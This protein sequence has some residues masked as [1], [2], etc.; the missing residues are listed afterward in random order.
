MPRP[1]LQPARS[2]T[3]SAPRW[4]DAASSGR[5][6]ASQGSGARGGSSSSA[7]TLA[8][9]GI[10]GVMSYSVSQR[11]PEIGIR[12]AL[13]ARRGD[14]LLLVLGQT[15]T[16]TAGGIAI[17]LAASLA[18]AHLMASL[19]YGV[20]PVDPLT[21]AAVAGLLVLVAA[22][23]AIIPARRAARVDPMVALRSE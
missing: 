18:L 2:S 17:G 21:F 11:T 7:R 15:L 16:M 14:V 13:G 8:F 12:M 23:A 4:T 1:V 9:I 20:S 6:R 22:A 3:R 10:H 19:V 5:A